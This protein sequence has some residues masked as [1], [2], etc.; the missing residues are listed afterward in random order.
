MVTR[1]APKLAGRGYRLDRRENALMAIARFALVALDCPDPTALAEFYA[2]I[3]GWEVTKPY[4]T[5]NWIELRS[6]AG[7]TIAFQRA[8]DHQPPQWPNPD[9]PQQAH[10]DFD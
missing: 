7:A 3:T 2:A 1:F 10:L 9:H 6:D 8:P 5:D 4:D